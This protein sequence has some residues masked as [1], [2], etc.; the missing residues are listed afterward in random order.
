MEIFLFTIIVVLLIIIL[1]KQQ[2]IITNFQIEIRN[3]SFK[4]DD[5][6]NQIDS[7]F[8]NI[9]VEEKV[10]FKEKP[11]EVE[12]IQEQKT[13]EKPIIGD[14]RVDDNQETQ[15][16]VLKEKVA[17]VPIEEMKP[18]IV[19]PIV[20]QTITIQTVS[21]EKPKPVF[22]PQP[23]VPKKY[24]YENFKERNPDLEKFIGENLISKIG[25]LIL[26]LGISFF[27]K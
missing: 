3:L 15:P 18:E 14:I 1:S 12:P 10:V 11:I 26:V 23:Y 16:V 17:S 22:E 7:K 21:Q 25:I 13:E 8:K 4:L 24:W 9:S 19:Q 6:K 20:Q 2:K 5:L 27:V